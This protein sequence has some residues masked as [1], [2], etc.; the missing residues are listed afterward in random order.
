MFLICLDQVFLNGLRYR[1]SPDRRCSFAGLLTGI[2]GERSGDRRL[3]VVSRETYDIGGKRAGISGDIVG[4]Y[5]RGEMK[6]SI[7]TATKLAAVLEVSLDYSV[8]TSLLQLPARSCRR[9]V[10]VVVSDSLSG[11][12]RMTF[13][14]TTRNSPR[15]RRS[16]DRR[17]SFA[18]L[19]T[20]LPGE[21]SGDRRL[22][23]VSR[24]TC[25]IG[26][27]WRIDCSTVYNF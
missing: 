20:G 27:I 23:V 19:L 11:S 5:E 2:S 15:Y 10:K 17:R 1:R 3:V 26:V 25:D 4:K 16:P 6:P 18:G 13:W 7:E 14:S 8:S 12:R 22:A 21:R 24:E 9:R